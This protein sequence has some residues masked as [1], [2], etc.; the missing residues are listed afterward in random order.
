VVG[1]RVEH[2]SE[3][4]NSFVP[5]LSLTKAFDT[6]HYKLL[7]SRAFRAPSMANILYFNPTY[8]QGAHILPEVSTIVEAEGGYRF[9]KRFF[10]N[11]NLYYIRISDPIVYFYDQDDSYDNFGAAS[12]WGG[13]LELRYQ[14]K[15]SYL[16]LSYAYYQSLDNTV[17]L[18]RVPRPGQ[19]TAEDPRFREDLVLG[20]PQHKLAVHHIVTLW[21]G[22]TLSTSAVLMSS[23][24]GYTHAD[25]EGNPLIGQLDPQLLLNAHLSYQNLFVQGLRAGLGVYNLLDAGNDYVQ[26]YNG[27]HAPLP[28]PSRELSLSL[29]YDRKF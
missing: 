3:A 24:Y 15:K 16:Y 13:E 23:R 26:P 17:A 21:R 19:E 2:H 10:L 27:G 8:S 29:G 9:S 28:G 20:I 7:L 1:G 6:F 11:A 4:G 14:G 22:L 12:T 25:S 5:R 18:Y